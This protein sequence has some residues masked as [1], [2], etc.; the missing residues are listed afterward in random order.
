MIKK[1]S[2]WGRNITINSKMYIPSSREELSI[3][4]KKFKKNVIT[5]GLGRSYGD[6]SL[7]RNLISLKKLKKVINFDINKGIIEVEAGINIEE[8]LK[9][10]IPYGWF[11]PV[12]PGT[13]FVTIGGAI[14]SDIHGKNHHKDGCFSKHCIKLMF[15][16]RNGKIKTC[17][18]KKNKKNFKKLCGGIGLAGIIVTAKIQLIKIKSN[19]IKQKIEK[20]ETVMSCIE[21]LEKNKNYKYSVSWIDL[22]NKNKHND[23][24]CIVYFGDHL[25]KKTKLNFIKNSKSLFFIFLFKS[26]FSVYSIKIFNYLK[27]K[28]SFYINYQTIVDYKKFFFPLDNILS[29]NTIYGEK[30]FIQYQLVISK[31]NVLEII[32]KINELSLKPLLVVLKILG[33]KNSNY[34]SFPKKGITI[35]MDFKNSKNNIKKLNILDDYII[36]KNGRI[37][38]TK[39]SITKEKKFKKMYPNWSIFHNKN[40]KKFSSLQSRRLNI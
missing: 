12:V 26:I 17:S 19:L 39:D 35:A 14:S 34:L 25:K 24:N 13:Q 27:F 2:G 4:L 37:Y 1:N 22:L 3:F 10:I 31:K 20:K 21:S 30:G 8:V 36:L 23:Y 16:D 29:W 33:N 28:L 7:N 11:L 9:L 5:R 6:T 15:F 40:K 32:A 18:S 38:L